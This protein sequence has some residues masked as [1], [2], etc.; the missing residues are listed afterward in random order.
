MFNIL[1]LLDLLLEAK[2]GTGKTAVFTVVAL[3]KLDLDKGLQVVI[4]APTREIAFQICDVIRQIGSKLEGLAVEVVIGGLP[5]EEDVSKFK[6]KVHIVVGSPGRF[7]HLVQD[8]H[9]DVS[10]VRLLVLDEGDKLL[11]KSFQAD[12]NFIFSIL[13]H[14][15]QV[16]FSSATYT[17]DTKLFL[18]KYVKNAQHVCP[19]SSC[20]LLGIVQKVTIVKYNA[21]IVRQTQNRFEELLKILSKIAFKQCLIFCNYQARVT[22]LHKL[23][24]RNKWPVEQ[25]YGQQEQTDRLGAL[26][27][28]Q[29]YKCRIL[30]A[31]DLAA[32]GID[33]SNV[34]LIINFEPP[35]EWQTYLHRIGRAGR[36]GSYGTSITILSEGKEEIKFREMLDSF[37]IPLNSLWTSDKN[38]FNEPSKVETHITLTNNSNRIEDAI[39]YQEF[40]NELTESVNKIEKIENFE[41]LCQSFNDSK[42]SIQSF[43]EL[44]KSFQEKQVPVKSNEYQHLQITAKVIDKL[45]DTLKILTASSNTKI[46]ENLTCKI[47]DY[48]NANSINNKSYGNKKECNNHS[49]LKKTSSYEK[50]ESN[51]HTKTH[52]NEPLSV[53]QKTIKEITPTKGLLCAGLPLSFASSKGSKNNKFNNTRDKGQQQ[54]VDLEE[55]SEIRARD[56]NTNEFQLFNQKSSVYSHRSAKSKKDYKIEYDSDNDA[57]YVSEDYVNW[58]K[59][60][61][62]RMKQIEL[63]LYIEEMSLQ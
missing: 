4:L 31:T 63:A 38:D 14:Q 16:I 50:I 47:K 49:I 44:L 11:D 58:Y 13:P 42:S 17:E 5:V 12:V 59:Q 18:S 6:K 21:N 40:W 51:K 61:K 39:E 20:V 30:I 27:T 54:T 53:R 36:F 56:I 24:V 29:D 55:T 28:L 2:S 37:K 25:L 15:K 8:K 43:N 57:C 9:I 19:D 52:G 3:E 35:F 26:K 1:L 10:S 48:E 22:E 46:N 41:T 60:L 32:R 23:L 45:S 7:R 62:L 33:A 34:D